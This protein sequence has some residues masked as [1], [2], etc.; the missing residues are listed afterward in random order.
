MQVRLATSTSARVPT[1]HQRPEMS[2]LQTELQCAPPATLAIFWLQAFARKISALAVMAQGQ[3][4]QSAPQMEH[5]NA[6]L[7][8]VATLL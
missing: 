4:E 8:T 7:A 1:A 3:Q 6:H 5:P 2:V